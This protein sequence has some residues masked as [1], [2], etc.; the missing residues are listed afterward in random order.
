MINFIPQVVIA[1]VIFV[2]GW[3]IAFF[4]G[5]VIEQ[6]FRSIKLDE[7]LKKTGLDDVMAKAGIVLNSGRFIG[8]LVKWFVIVVFLIAAFNVLKLNQVNDFLQGVVVL[9]IPRVIVA[10]LILLVS[11]VIADTLKKVVISSTKVAG[12]TSAHL[13]G[14]ITKWIIWT[15]AILTALTELGIGGAILNTLLTGVVVAFSVAFGLAFGLGGQQAA[16]EIISKVKQEI[17][18]RRG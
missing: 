15:V 9:Y 14:S 17:S 6:I 13:L 7:A 3:I 12:L 11:A 1:I 10:V 8:G 18:E 2:V 4:V 5:R 16:S